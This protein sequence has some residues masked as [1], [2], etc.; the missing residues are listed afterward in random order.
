MGGFLS[1]DSVFL[2]ICFAGTVLMKDQFLQLVEDL[3]V[4][5]HFVGWLSENGVFSHKSLIFFQE[6]GMCVSQYRGEITLH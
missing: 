6:G 3:A 1:D 2:L 4:A 5:P